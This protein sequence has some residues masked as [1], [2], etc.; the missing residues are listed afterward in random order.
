M[1]YVCPC[2][3]A[4]LNTCQPLPVLFFCTVTGWSAYF[5]EINLNK[6]K[7]AAGNKPQQQQQQQEQELLLPQQH[8]QQQ[9][10]VQKQQQQQQQQQV[11]VPNTGDEVLKDTKDKAMSQPLGPNAPKDHQQQ[12][13]QQQASKVDA[14]SVLGS[15]ASSHLLPAS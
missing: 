11:L 5:D 8:V 7:K 9:Q 1:P 2:S 12:Q 10:V 6:T 3:N 4:N 13:Q 14:Q 15:P